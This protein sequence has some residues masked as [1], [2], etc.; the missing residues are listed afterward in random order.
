MAMI[1][2][3]Q[4]LWCYVLWCYGILA[5]PD[6]ISSNSFSQGITQASLVLSLLRSSF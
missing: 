3:T 1:C 2:K 5:A 6:L 4:K